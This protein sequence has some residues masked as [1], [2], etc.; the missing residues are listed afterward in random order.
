[1]ASA[2]LDNGAPIS[3]VQQLLGHSTT[4]V[5]L[6]SYPAY[7]PVYDDESLRQG[8]DQYRSRQ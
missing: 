5:T 1:M 4:T 3:L 7:D 6:Q 2:M 8:F